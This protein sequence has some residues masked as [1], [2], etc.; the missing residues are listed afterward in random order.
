MIVIGVDVHKHSLILLM[1]SWLRWTGGLV[2]GTVIRGRA[3]WTER[4]WAVET[5]ARHAPAGADSGG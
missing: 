1:I 2:D 3:R 5:A 4:L